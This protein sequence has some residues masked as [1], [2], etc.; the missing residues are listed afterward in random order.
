MSQLSSACALEG[1]SAPERIDPYFDGL[2]AVGGSASWVDQL[3]ARQ[4]VEAGLA[5][6]PKAWDLDIE[7]ALVSLSDP[8]LWAERLAVLAAIGMWRTCTVEQLAAISG[9]RSANRTTNLLLAHLFAAG[10]VD[11]GMFVNA[12][13]SVRSF[14]RRNLVRPSRGDVFVTEVEPRLTYTEW[15]QV[16]GGVPWSTGGTYD[17]H[18]VLATELGLRI[19]EYVPALPVV[20]GEPLSTHDMMYGSGAGSE[21]LTQTAARR[22][23]LSVVRQD[24]LRI[25]IEVAASG[26]PS[27]NRKAAYWADQLSRPSG[28]GMFVLFVTAE[29]LT[30]R[31][32]YHDVE[33]RNL[34]FKGVSQAVREF[35]GPAQRPTALRMGVV[36]WREWFPARHTVTERFLAG[37]VHRPTGPLKDRWE[38]FVLFDSNEPAPVFASEAYRTAIFDNAHLLL[39]SPF[40][41]RDASRAPQVWEHL[42]RASSWTELPVPEV[43]HSRRR[44]RDFQ[45]GSGAAGA[46]EPPK[47]LQNL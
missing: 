21:P 23:D 19:A 10:V 18:N 32:K 9:V 2:F 1:F 45:E 46:P 5:S 27:L 17:R 13:S 3:T 28:Q 6:I 43:E 26:G 20:V 7:E 33:N 30:P 25:I 16:T 44:V 39:G 41:L 22:G 40:W 4:Q 14:E 37:Q 15:L 47:R 42:I 12:L 8:Q 38:P 31:R 35:P 29:H 34:V 11:I 36:S 24:G